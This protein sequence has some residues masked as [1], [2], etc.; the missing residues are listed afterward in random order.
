MLVVRC[1]RCKEVS[2]SDSEQWKNTAVVYD[3][4]EDTERQALHF[5]LCPRCVRE[6]LGFLNG[7]GVI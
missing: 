7:W 2:K 3:L 6:V 5:H 1:D 4:T